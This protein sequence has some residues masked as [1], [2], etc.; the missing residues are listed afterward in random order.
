MLFWLVAM[1]VA[2]WTR[3]VLRLGRARDEVLAV[4]AASAH[5]VREDEDNANE[6]EETAVEMEKK[7]NAYR[8]GKARA[9]PTSRKKAASV[10][11]RRRRDK[12]VRTQSKMFDPGGGVQRNTNSAV[13]T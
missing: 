3:V 4:A 11:G 5:Q 9:Q 12:A 7:S 6:E 13:K 1:S 2:L 10:A 8:Q